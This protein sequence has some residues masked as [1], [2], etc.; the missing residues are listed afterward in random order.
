MRQYGLRIRPSRKWPR[1][2]EILGHR[3]LRCGAKPV[4]RD[5]ILPLACGGSNHPS[6]LQPLCAEC[7]RKKG[8]AT[9]DYRTPEQRALILKRWPLPHSMKSAALGSSS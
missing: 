5:H 8:A 6:N 2:L 1:V 3:C 9:M 7:N 4:T